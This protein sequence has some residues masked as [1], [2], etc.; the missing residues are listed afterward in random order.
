MLAIRAVEGQWADLPADLRG[1]SLHQLIRFVQRTNRDVLR[2]TRDPL[3]GRGIS[4][5]PE[6]RAIRF[7]GLA[8][9]AKLGQYHISVRPKFLKEDTSDVLARLAMI[10]GRGITRR[11]LIQPELVPALA[12]Q[13]W[14]DPIA[15]YFAQRLARAIEQGPLL[16]TERQAE[17][18][19]RIRGRLLVTKQLTSS[20][21]L[22]HKLYYSY[23]K[24]NRANQAVALLRWACDRL[25]ALSRHPTAKKKLRAALEL[26]PPVFI[27]SVPASITR[28]LAIPS[29]APYRE[30]L[31][32]AHELWRR[33]LWKESD[34]QGDHDSWGFLIVTHA[35]FEHLV[36]ATFRIAA[37]SLALR[38]EAQRP[39]TLRVLHAPN[40]ARVRRRA[41]FLDDALVAPRQRVVL[42]S[43]TKYVIASTV[44]EAQSRDHFNQVLASC[45]ASGADRGMLVYPAATGQ[46]SGLAERWLIT[47]DIIPRQ[48]IIG[49]FYLS[50]DALSDRQ[51]RELMARQLHAGAY[52][53]LAKTEDDT[54]LSLL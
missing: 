21:H 25:L 45:V 51:F 23:S 31:K 50:M 33:G 13:S 36:S 2:F 37:R 28:I 52:V 38:H 40:V 42:A 19:S 41:V 43:E 12:G 34:E 3:A 30:V 5:D 14:A 18:G 27:R 32:I 48:L 4:I 22:P 46:V 9:V 6:R 17:F 10:D 15:V 26:L 20:P 44:R 49:V 35:A 29:A 24:L 47:S 53:M 16:I 39:A 8:G 1:A 11:V 54:Q 7:D